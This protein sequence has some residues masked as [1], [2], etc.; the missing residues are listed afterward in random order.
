TG[1][2]GIVILAK[3]GPT[4]AGPELVIGRRCS[5]CT[6]PPGEPLSAALLAADAAP[7]CV[8]LSWLSL[9]PAQAPDGHRVRPSFGAGVWG[10]SRSPLHG[11]APLHPPAP[12]PSGREKAGNP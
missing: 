7:A 10:R 6:G 3:N 4:G 8:Q 12:S 2:G 9:E 1:R 5:G 11:T